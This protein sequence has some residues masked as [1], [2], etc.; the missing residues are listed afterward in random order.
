MELGADGKTCVCKW[1]Y[2]LDEDGNCVE[3]V[4]STCNEDE[5][6]DEENN[7]CVPKSSASDDTGDSEGTGTTG[8]SGGSGESG[9]SDDSGDTGNSDGE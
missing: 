5:E 7:T 4:E 1:G 3:D 6:Y 9:E 8:D 2:S